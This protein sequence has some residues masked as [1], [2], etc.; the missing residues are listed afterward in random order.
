MER[1]PLKGTVS[2][3]TKQDSESPIS[4]TI[5]FIS[6]EKN[7]QGGIDRG[8]TV[9]LSGFMSP[10]LARAGM[11]LCL[12]AA[13]NGRGSWLFLKATV[14]LSAG[15]DAV[16]FYLSTG[17]IAHLTVPAAVR[18]VKHFGRDSLLVLDEHP[19]KIAE[20]PGIGPSAKTRVEQNWQ[21]DRELSHAVISTMSIGLS[22][23]TARRAVEHFGLSAADRLLE[24]PY[25]LT[26][27]HG[28]G[29]KKADLFA[30]ARGIRPD[31]KTRIQ[32][33]SW[34]CLN[35]A[36]SE[37]HTYLPLYE[38][39]GRVARETGLLPEAVRKVSLPGNIVLTPGDKVYA[40]EL[41]EAERYVSGCIHK[42]SYEHSFPFL[43][44]SDIDRILTSKTGL[45]R[46]QRQAL[47][48]VLTGPR[49]SV[50][51]GMPGTGK[52]TLIRTL[53]DVLREAGVRCVLAAPTGKAAS[54]IAS[55]TGQ[56]A[57]TIHRLLGISAAGTS[58]RNKDNPLDAGCIVI[59]EFSMVNLLL[60]RSILEAVPP[61]SVLILVGDDHQLPAIGPGAILREMKEKSL[62]NITT[63]SDIHRQ[64]SRSS[65]VILAH[66]IQN[67]RVPQNVFGKKGCYFV[68]E[69]DLKK[70]RMTVI[71]LA[72]ADPDYPA[73]Q[74]QVLTPMRKS[75]IGTDQLNQDLREK[76]RPYNIERLMNMGYDSTPS[77]TDDHEFDIGDRV[78][79]RANNYRKAVYNGE[80]GY[81][82]RRESS[83]Y[84]ERIVILFDDGREIGYSEREWGQLQL[85]YACTVHAYQ[86]SEVPCCIIPLHATNRI[87]LSRSLL[88]TAV[89]RAREKVI[90]AGSANALAM[91]V[92]NNRPDRRYANLFG[93][94]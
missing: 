94:V 89:T 83:Q 45:A 36:G 57:S 66:A 64:D 19:D 41:Y 50:I 18:I 78:I 7:L 44:R 2:A 70:L 73:D 4:H 91:A 63:L 49:L 6:S 38:L 76:I 75:Q 84:G 12:T 68:Q 93:A 58:T 37:G 81:V 60:M 52:T 25:Q 1:I 15:G 3:V 28:Y 71:E 53:I 23:F 11:P 10:V 90:L 54:R 61:K 67:G 65:I 32:A 69:G 77:D 22:L 82:V 86:G 9:I 5:H 62:C 27:V 92:K 39:T 29:F 35:A 16:L 74:I 56:S 33:A 87:M 24:D 80:I 13:R 40:R 48:N 85:A 8:Q 55:Q 46:D 21:K 17:A 51:T 43:S 20:V 30:R 31:S 47:F 79:Q 26:Y 42:M 34:Y 88:Y 72:T 14:D 59:D